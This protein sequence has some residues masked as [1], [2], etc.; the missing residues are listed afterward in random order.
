[1][2]LCGFHLIHVVYIEMVG[3]VIYLKWRWCIDRK[4][5]DAALRMETVIAVWGAG[6]FALKLFFGV[7]SVFGYLFGNSYIWIHYGKFE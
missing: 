6:I 7:S 2:G 4:A 5:D 1:M 3:R